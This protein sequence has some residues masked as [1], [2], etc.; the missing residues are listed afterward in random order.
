MENLFYKIKPYI[1]KNSIEQDLML[2]RYLNQVGMNGLC[3]I[4]DIGWHGSMQYFLEE[5]CSIKKIGVQ[6]LGFYV[7]IK[8]NK[9]IVGTCD[10]YLYNKDNFKLRKDVLCFFGGY[11]KLF[12]SCEGSTYGYI[13]QD[14]V[15]RPVFADYEYHDN[16]QF[17]NYINEWQSGAL[18][19]VKI[20]CCNSIQ[21]KNQKQWAY[22]LIKFGKNPSMKD[23]KL[24]NNFYNTDGTKV[25]YVSQKPL[26]KYRPRE[27][28][29]ALSNSVWKTGFMKSLF[30]IPF[31]YF[32]VYCLLKK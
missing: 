29:H 8:P 18:K 7:G 9:H 16:L 17:I 12:Q 32:Y 4:V 13:L 5:Y 19:F 22:P 30:K 15:I 27:L 11:E 24:F 23:I 1:D 3:A 10:G 26:Y 6:F 2:E 28:V 14:D 25:Y 20:V 31:P 21:L